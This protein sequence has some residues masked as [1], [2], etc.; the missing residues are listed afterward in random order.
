[1]S[2]DMVSCTSSS[3]NG[4]MEEDAKGSYFKNDTNDFLDK[5]CDVLEQWRSS[6]IHDRTEQALKVLNERDFDLD[7]NEYSVSELNRLCGN[8]D[9]ILVSIRTSLN[10]MSQK[11]KKTNNSLIILG[12]T[13][14]DKILVLLAPYN[15]KQVYV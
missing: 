2:V 6:T 1:M 10:D 8:V 11:G 14:V 9:E 15:R 4:L 3:Q 5:L 7:I 13:L 12:T